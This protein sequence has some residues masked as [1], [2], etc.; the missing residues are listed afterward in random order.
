MADLNA[1]WSSVTRDSEEPALPVVHNDELQDLP[2]HEVAE[3]PASET[4]NSESIFPLRHFPALGEPTHVPALDDTVYGQP[5]SA[6][7]EPESETRSSEAGIARVPEESHQWAT[8][9]R[10]RHADEVSTV[11]PDAVAIQGQ[12]LDLGAFIPI[13]MSVVDH[14]ARRTEI[15]GDNRDGSPDGPSL[16]LAPGSISAT[17]SS[18]NPFIHDMN[19]RRP[20][21]AHLHS[22]PSPDRHPQ[23]PHTRE[24]Y[25]ATDDDPTFHDLGWI[26]YVLPDR[27]AT[28]YVQPTL[29]TTTDA[30][31]RDPTMLGSVSR[32][33]GGGAGYRGN[34]GGSRQGTMELWL[35]DWDGKGGIAGQKRLGDENASASVGVR[36]PGRWKGK[37]KRTD[38]RR[39]S[40]DAA[41]TRWWVDHL[42]REVWVADNL[43]QLEDH[44]DME[45]RYWAFMESHPAHVALPSGAQKEAID[46]LT[47]ALMDQV[48][49]QPDVLLASPFTQTECQEL[50]RLLR[51]SGDGSQIDTDVH[52]T[53]T[54]R[55]VS[56]ILL[57]VGKFF[58]YVKFQWNSIQ[59]YPAQ[60]QKALSVDTEN[61][62]IH[63]P[64]FIRRLADLLLSCLLLGVPF[65]SYTRTRC[66]MG[67]TESGPR[68]RM[69]PTLLIGV[70]I[71]LLAAILLGASV[72]FLSLPGFYGIPRAMLLTVMILAAGA[73]ITS[74]VALFWCQAEPVTAPTNTEAVVKREGSMFIST[75][76][77]ILSLPLTLFM[78]AV[79]VFVA[80]FLLDSFTGRI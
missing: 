2:S 8:D 14:E 67:D 20:L 29:H 45:I 40:E 55:I 7:P 54:T 79:L 59:F 77:I 13:I 68:A 19:E 12:R 21:L 65:L 11:D 17:P 69:L 46:V 78:Y 23:V 1:E 52:S 51:Q 74:V 70:C 71:C 9:T 27:S 58:P 63:S 49:A 32:M 35:S 62:K 30:D 15:G 3:V 16:N 31:L 80:T 53:G 41:L 57:R 37:G 28:Y 33:L 22:S 39:R 38:W 24:S 76:S 61:N 36:S 42:T 73:I 43:V 75:R 50:L 26:A 47:W 5:T 18:E 72:T 6:E 56:R 34:D 10:F 66:R 48:L 25:G 60:H 44:L 4:P 64:G